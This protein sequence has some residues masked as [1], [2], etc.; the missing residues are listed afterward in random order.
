MTVYLKFGFWWLIAYRV[1]SQ[2]L[3]STTIYSSKFLHIIVLSVCVLGVRCSYK[4]KPLG[5]YYNNSHLF[6]TLNSLNFEATSVTWLLGIFNSQLCTEVRRSWDMPTVTIV[7][8]FSLR[9]RLSSVLW[10]MG[11]GQHVYVIVLLWFGLMS[12]IYC[13]DVERK[14]SNWLAGHYL[15]D[16]KK[17]IGLFAKC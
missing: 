14:M 12:S 17:V 6:R 9:Q 16:Q 15:P 4:F 2:V 3:L 11:S 13:A 1:S 5:Q 8:F 10:V 7:G